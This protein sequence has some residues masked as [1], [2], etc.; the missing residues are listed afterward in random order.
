MAIDRDNIIEVNFKTG[1]V[2][3]PTG[4]EIKK[5]I[6]RM[7]KSRT[8]IAHLLDKVAARFRK[9]F[10]KLADTLYPEKISART[11]KKT[12]PKWKKRVDGLSLHE[13]VQDRL[14][15]LLKKG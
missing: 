7:R 15:R 11:P 5:S 2:V 10:P 4:L 12:L 1:T 3:D 6:T 9:S 8:P 14:E 13:S